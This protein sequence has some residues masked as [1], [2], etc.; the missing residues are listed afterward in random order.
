MNFT[1]GLLL[2]FY[3]CLLVVIV[4]VITVYGGMDMFQGLLRRCR[5]RE[6]RK[7]SERSAGDRDGIARA[8]GSF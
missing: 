7:K 3:H 8:N 4:V 1:V 6:K 2:L 5:K